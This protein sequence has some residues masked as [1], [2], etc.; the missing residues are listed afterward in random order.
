MRN[1][2][3]DAFFEECELLDVVQKRLHP[4]NELWLLEIG[5]VPVLIQCQE[6]VNRMRIVAFIADAAQFGEDELRR[7]LD[8]NYHSA[9][10]VRY[11]LADGDLVAAFLH[12]LDQ[13]DY[14]QFVLGLFQVVSCA[15][16]W[17]TLYSGGSMVLGGGG[18]ATAAGVS[19]PAT[20]DDVAAGSAV[21]DQIEE[22]KAE[23]IQ[24]IRDDNGSSPLTI[25]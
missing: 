22:I 9:L 7:L 15:E 13:L 8:A 6:S 21:E 5:G 3:I 16:T 2:D 19:A 10:D 18:R 4:P 17:G 24:R 14:A 11:A 25:N 1:I 20:G 12:P 23:I